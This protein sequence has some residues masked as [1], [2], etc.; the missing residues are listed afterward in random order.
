MRLVVE[1]AASVHIAAVS[2]RAERREGP[3]LRIDRDDVGVP[4]EEDGLFLPVAFEPRNEIGPIRFAREDL[5]G[6]PFLFEHLFE[7]IGHGH[8]VARGIARIEAE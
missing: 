1:R 4:H 2:R 3:F 6:N 5:D 7:V 8:F